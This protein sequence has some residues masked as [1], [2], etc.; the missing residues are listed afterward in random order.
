MASIESCHDPEMD[1]PPIEQKWPQ[2]GFAHVASYM[3]SQKTSIGLTP[4]ICGMAALRNAT[5]IWRRS[6][7]QD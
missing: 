3:G 4:Q 7:G 5:R 6:N 1:G 2:S